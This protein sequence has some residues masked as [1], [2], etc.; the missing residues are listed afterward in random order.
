MSG[1]AVLYFCGACKLCIMNIQYSRLSMVHVRNV[2]DAC[3]VSD[4]KDCKVPQR[5]QQSKLESGR[6]KEEQQQDEEGKVELANFVPLAVEEITPTATVCLMSRT[7]KRP[8]GGNSENAF[9]E[10]SE[11]TET[12]DA[13]AAALNPLMCQVCYKIFSNKGNKNKHS[14]NNNCGKRKNNNSNKINNNNIDK[15]NSNDE[16]MKKRRREVEIQILTTVDD[17]TRHLFNKF[18]VGKYAKYRLL[19]KLE[20][21]SAEGG[22]VLFDYK[23][24]TN[25]PVASV[26]QTTK[27]EQIMSSIIE[28][29]YRNHGVEAVQVPKRCEIRINGKTHNVTQY[30]LPKNKSKFKIRDLGDFF[31]LSL[32][33]HSIERINMDHNYSC[34]SSVPVPSPSLAPAQPATTPSLHSVATVSGASVLKPISTPSQGWRDSVW[35]ARLREER[36]ETQERSLSDISLD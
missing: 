35:R 25:S 34:C 18:V 21:T 33:A 19:Q 7:A 10:N 23:A 30:L 15:I 5:M 22:L 13:T 32:F 14:T 11:E 17:E 31:E 27:A 3:L 12:G 8:S 28:D 26:C 36:Q 2:A 1:S 20:K 4:L 29:A 9:K 24:H 6:W 16:T